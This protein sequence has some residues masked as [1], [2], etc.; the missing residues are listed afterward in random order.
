VLACGRQMML[1]NSA[2]AAAAVASAA[3]A[4]DVPGRTHSVALLRYPAV[5][6]I[7]VN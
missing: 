6:V 1:S 4:F 5:S 3:S 2:A 7:F